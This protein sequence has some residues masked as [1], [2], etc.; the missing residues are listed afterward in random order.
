MAFPLRNCPI[1]PNIANDI[2]RRTARNSVADVNALYR[3]QLEALW[4]TV[5]GS[6][7]F[8]PIIPGRHLLAESRTFVELNSITYKPKHNVHLFLLNDALL[9]A[10][11]KRTGMGSSKVKLIADKCFNVADISVVDLKDGGGQ[12]RKVSFHNPWTVYMVPTKKLAHCF[13]NLITLHQ[14]L[15]NAIKIKRGRESVIFRTDRTEDKKALLSSFKKVADE[16]S[17]RK[18]KQSIMDAENRRTVSA[19][20]ICFF[21]SIS[22]CTSDAM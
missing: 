20:T 8:L 22:V 10:V 2:R 14:D 6:Q 7:K 9:V 11:S 21:S 5:E 3:T 18:R 16:L 17:S 12:Y 19:T 15:E 1:S 4:E 13:F